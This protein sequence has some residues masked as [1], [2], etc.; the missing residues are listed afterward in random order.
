MTRGAAPAASDVTFP[1]SEL[2]I[3]ETGVFGVI[4]LKTLKISHLNWNCL[5]PN[6]KERDS[7]RST[8]QR[9]GPRIASSGIVP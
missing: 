4:V 6:R 9:P 1:K 8:F 7:D 2:F 5:R 3:V